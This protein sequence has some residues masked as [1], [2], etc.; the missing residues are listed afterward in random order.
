MNL[1]L[2]KT[3]KVKWKDGTINDIFVIS[4][5]G[6]LYKYNIMNQSNGMK[7]THKDKINEEFEIL[8]EKQ[9]GILLD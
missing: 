8:E 9:P 4:L 1:K 2:N 3:Y 7:Y 6:D 5:Y